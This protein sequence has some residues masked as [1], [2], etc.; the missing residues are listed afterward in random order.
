MARTSRQLTVS[1]PPQLYRKAMAVAR[2][3]FR[4][5]SELVREALREYMARRETVAA[6]RKQLARNLKEKGIR[7]LGDIERM[8][9]A[10]RT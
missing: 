4:S 5:K 8:I 9:D 3:E 2:A 1:L 6:A 7:N 10:G